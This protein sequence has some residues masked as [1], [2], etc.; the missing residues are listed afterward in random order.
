MICVGADEIYMTR[1][2]ELGPI[3]P[4]FTVNSPQMGQRQYASTDLFAYLDFAKDQ[5]GW[6]PS[7]SESSLALL[8]FFHKHSGISPDH[9]GKIYRMYTQS[10][11]Y[12]SELADSHSEGFKLERIAVTTLTETL[13]KG[14]GSHDYKIDSHEAKFK[15]GLN[16]LDYDRNVEKSV[17][18][19]YLKVA[20]ELKLNQPFMPGVQSAG[21]QERENLGLII[22]EQRKSFKTADI[23]VVNLGQQTALDMK[24][25]PWVKGD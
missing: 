17:N 24:A 15:L 18:E 6:Q 22:C 19:L 1:K 2:A 11:K 23:K 8:E 25:S 9:I 13:M 7:N 10:S 14:F 21:D 4:Q 20:G 12:V 16:V 3:D 5:L